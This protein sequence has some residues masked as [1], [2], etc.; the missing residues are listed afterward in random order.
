MQVNQTTF[1]SYLFFLFG[2]LV[3]LLGSSIAQFVIVW[4][5]TL[6]TESTLYLSLASVLGFAPIVIL[7]PLTGVLADRWNRKALIGTVDLLQALTSV[8]LI[9]LFQLNVIAIWQVLA[10]L[11]LK[12][13]FQAFHTPAVLAM[14]P[15]MVPK[16]KLSRLN[17]VNY[18]FTSSV[19]LAGLVV[20]AVLLGFWGIS[21][22]LWIDA[23]TFLVALVPL[24]MITIPSIIKKQ[25]K[26]SFRK[27]FGK[28]FAF[29]RKAR[30]L[31]PFI[32]V[33]TG[34]NFLLTH[35]TTLL[36]YFVKVDHFG[37]VS[38]LA[39]VMAFIQ[40]GLLVGGLIMSV[41]KVSRKKMAIIA[42][43]MYILFLGY[44]LVAL[45]PTEFFW[46]MATSGLILTF[47][48]PMIDVLA[49]TI[50][51]TVVP[52]EMQ[53]R[54]T[55]V[56]ISLAHAAQPIGMLLA[57]IITVFTGTVNLFLGCAGLGV[58]ILTLSWFFTDVRYVEKLEENSTNKMD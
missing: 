48:I 33:A 43:S 23:A 10:L 18:L 12:G 49:M 52:V 6:E 4:W 34:V 20:A 30:G 1:R 29:I 26:S 58:L 38:D 11:T 51:Q 19:N 40:G 57:G 47:C 46:F 35:L 24:L 9:F 22:I 31:L 28:G 55:S 42:S 8:A 27:Q 44:I 2:Q 25:D 53:G 39:F 50:L 5:I 3:S 56:T 37:A 14:I 13:V 7:G 32:M 45:T 15:T 36:P 21:Q 16:D 41:I 54:V 17:G